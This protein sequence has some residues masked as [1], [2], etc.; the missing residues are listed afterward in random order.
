[1]CAGV[2]RTKNGAGLARSRVTSDT[3]FGLLFLLSRPRLCSCHSQDFSTGGCA[4][5]LL[6]NRV[7]GFA[8]VCRFRGSNT[9]MR[10][11]TDLEKEEQKEN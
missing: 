11:N 9:Q 6:A 5:F 3:S 7:I 1:M 8:C 2:C 10:I 4:L